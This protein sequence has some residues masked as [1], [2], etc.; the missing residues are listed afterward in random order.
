MK[1]ILVA[2]ILGLAASVSVYGQGQ[3]AFDN[4]D[5]APY[6]PV[7]YAQNGSSAA[8]FTHPATSSVK[9]EL[10]YGLGVVN[11]LAGLT[12]SGVSL[13]VSDALSQAGTANGAPA[14]TRDSKARQ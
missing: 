11:S 10:L 5:S 8:D 9:V 3:I 13:S 7:V 14:G 6:Y 2:S 4:Y 12:D 1:K